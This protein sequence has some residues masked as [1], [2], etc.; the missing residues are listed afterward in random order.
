[1]K[2]QHYSNELWLIEWWCENSCYSG[3]D[4]KSCQQEQML[5][6]K[7]SPQFGR[8]ADIMQRFYFTKLPNSWVPRQQQEPLSRLEAYPVSQEPGW[9]LQRWNGSEW[10]VMISFNKYSSIM[11]LSFLNVYFQWEKLKLSDFEYFVDDHFYRCKQSHRRW[12]F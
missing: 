9:T 4:R 1:M 10:F 7:L 2:R 5:R 11:N 6:Q 8:R 12:L 3:H